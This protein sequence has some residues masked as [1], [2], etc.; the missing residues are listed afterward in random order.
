MHH[1]VNESVGRLFRVHEAPCGVYGP[2]FPK[3]C[4]EQC[5]AGAQ[6]RTNLVRNVPAPFKVP[7]L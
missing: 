4:K 3:H 7:V 2:V 1:E 6:Q 5:S